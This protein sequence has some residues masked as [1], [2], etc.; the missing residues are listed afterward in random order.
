MHPSTQEERRHRTGFWIV[1]AVFALIM[2]YATVPTPLY[3]LYEAADGFDASL[4]TVIFA[5]F[6][7]GVLISLY[8]AGHISDTVGR[9]RVLLASTLIAAASALL[10]TLSPAVPMLLTARLVSGLSVGILTATATAHLGELRAIA[11]PGESPVVAAAVAGAANLGGLALG[12]L[13]GGLFARFLPAPLVLPHAV[14]LAALVAAALTLLRVPETVSPAVPRPAWRPQRIAP[15]REGRGAFWI[16]ALAGFAA[17]GVF[18]LFTSLAPAYLVRVFHITDHLVAGLTT[19]A[20]FGAAA[21]CQV[22]LARQPLRLQL[23]LAAIAC[24]TGL[25]GVGAGALTGVFALFLL[26]AIVSGAGVGVLFRAALQSTI[27]AAAP[28][29]RGAAIALYFFI[30][31]T[32]LAVP[33]L[34]VGA[35]LTVFSAD[36]VL[37]A[38]LAISWAATVGT[39]IRMSRG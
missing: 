35:A 33:V 38:F 18:G 3:P 26:S 14:Y 30:G 36:S 28:E 10:F 6:A 39:G 29:R 16:A 34:L 7:I 37:I 15:P 1:T 11:R 20:V 8:L 13:V 31:Y 27:A 5:A 17:F 19:F 2:S 24:G 32:G 4:T 22:L 25:V 23:L 9:R 12:P 21:L